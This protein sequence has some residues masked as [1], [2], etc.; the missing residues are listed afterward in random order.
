MCNDADEELFLSRLGMAVKKAREDLNL[1]QRQFADACSI[2]R[3]YLLRAEKGR[4]VGILYLKRICETAG[5][6]LPQ[7]LAFHKAPPK[8]KKR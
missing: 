6:S 2:H 5:I 7:L 1:S 8:Q 3:T 4:N